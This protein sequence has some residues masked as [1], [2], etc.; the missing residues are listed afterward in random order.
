M[1]TLA[2]ITNDDVLRELF[3]HLRND[4]RA[5]MCSVDGDPSTVEGWAWAGIPWAKG[6]RCP[7]LSKRNNYV[8]ISSF[9]QADDGKYRRRKDQF[10]A[11]HAIMVDDVGTKLSHKAL[12]AT[13]A[14]SMAIETSPGNYQVTY[15]LTEPMYDQTEAESAVRQMIAKLTDGGV[16]PGMAGVTRVLRLPGGING[17]PKYVTPE[18]QPWVCRLAYWRP[19]IR[20]SWTD[21]CRAYGIVHTRKIFVEPDDDVSRERR[22]G[23]EIVLQG[24][25]QLGII[26]RQ[27]RGWVDVRCPWLREHT[28]RADT[29]AAVAYPAKPN[30]FMGGFRCHHGHCQHRNWG[31]LEDW[32]ADAVVENGRRTRGMF[33]GLIENHDNST[34]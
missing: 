6:G 17:K 33:T 34:T 23:F 18:G 10:G 31:D 28:D 13:I 32:V 30:G 24:M 26:K 15:F 3:K 12:P 2:D 8:A 21:L 19:D 9:T 25:Q 1:T 27:G 29:G 20:T 14:P 7:L 22:R 5:V 4:Q 11:V 16:D